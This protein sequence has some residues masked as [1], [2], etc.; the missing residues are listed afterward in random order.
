LDVV[1][2]DENGTTLLQDPKR[3]EKRRRHGALIGCLRS[4]IRTQEGDVECT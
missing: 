3:S 4:R 1:N 2:R